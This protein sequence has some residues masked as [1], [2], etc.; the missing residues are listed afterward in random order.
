MKR[1][2]LFLVPFALC[3]MGISAFIFAGCS[4]EAEP[5]STPSAASSS[6]AD[7]AFRDQLKG[8]R[9][10]RT[11]ALAAR[12]TVTAQM[13]A[14]VEAVKAKLKTDDEKLIKA[15]LEKDPEWQSLYKRCTD[16]NAAVEEQRQKTLK[17]VREKLRRETASARKA[18]VVGAGGQE[19]ASAQGAL[20]PEKKISK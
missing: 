3:A 2:S 5:V 9:A 11:A 8:L 18:D 15:E 13:K 7:G 1:T 20:V 12:D 14:K 16:A 4:R 19:A 6:A 10:E 17:A